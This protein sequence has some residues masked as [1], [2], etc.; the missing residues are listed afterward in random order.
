MYQ[1]TH[2]NGER[3]S[4]A[5]AY[6]HAAPVAPQP[7]RDHRRARRRASCS[8][9]GAPSAWN[10]RQGGALKQLRARRE[11]LLVRRR[12]AVAAAAD[13]LGHRPGTRSCSAR[14]SRPLHDLPGVGRNLHD[15]VDVVQVVEC[16]AAHGSVRPVI[17]RR[18][19]TCMQGHPRVAQHRARHADH[20]LRRGR[21][22]HQEPAGRADSRPAAAF[23]DR[24]A[25]RTTAARPSSATATPAMSCLLRPKS[26]GSVTLAS[27]DPLR[28]AADRPELPRP[29]ATTSSA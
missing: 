20:Q 12:A 17:R 10:T 2:K 9:A 21:R 19:A 1:V 6:L 5:K 25:G 8:K 22:L 7:A 29:S 15:H 13:A 16:A 18:A 14:A 28:R 27:T 11:V 26:R 24:Q 3:F 4:A 23:R